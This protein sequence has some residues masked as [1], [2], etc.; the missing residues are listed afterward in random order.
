VAEPQADDDRDEREYRVPG[1]VVWAAAVACREAGPSRRIAPASPLLW[2]LL[3]QA[4]LRASSP[5]AF[6]AAGDR[7]TSATR[8]GQGLLCTWLVMEGSGRAELFICTVCHP[9]GGL[10]AQWAAPLPAACCT[11]K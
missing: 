8:N 9:G 7:R 11:P 1:H 4:A 5:G 3:L 6:S 2:A 10:Q